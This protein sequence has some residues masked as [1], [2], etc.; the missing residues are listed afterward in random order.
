MKLIRALLEEFSPNV[1]FKVERK[2]PAWFAAGHEP[3]NA[4]YG[5]S[6]ISRMSYKEGEL[7][8]GDQIHWLQGG[9]FAVSFNEAGERYTDVI[10]LA[11]P[12]DLSPFERGPNSHDERNSW[13]KPLIQF[14]K[15]T[16]ID[17]NNASDTI[18]D[19]KYR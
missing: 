15:I 14:G 1:Y 12:E 19:V 10:R 9:L 5:R 3:T 17:K 11:A 13:I 8:P 6:R 2:I 7:N 4:S 18:F 16:K